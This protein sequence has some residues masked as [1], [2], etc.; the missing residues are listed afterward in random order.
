[1]K[2]LSDTSPGVNSDLSDISLGQNMAQGLFMEGTMY[3]SRLMHNRCRNSWPHQHSPFG[4]HQVP[5]K[6]LSP[7][8]RQRLGSGS[9]DQGVILCK[10]KHP[11]QVPGVAYQCQLSFVIFCWLFYSHFWIKIGSE[12]FFFLLSNNLYFQLEAWWCLNAQKH[13]GSYCWVNI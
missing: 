2:I 8:S 4:V 1:M 12:N 13:V 7:A 9:C 6:K 10:H 11:A 5:S 3:K